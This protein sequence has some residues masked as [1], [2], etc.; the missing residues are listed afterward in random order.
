MYDIKPDLRFKACL[1]CDGSRVDPRGLST[2]AT[3]VKVISV[4][5]LDLI[6]DAHN[7]DVIVGDI[8]NAFI[9]AKTKEKIYTR[10]GKEF[11]DRAHCIVLIKRAL[12]GLTIGAA[13]FRTLLAVFLRTPDFK[14]TR[15][16][17]DVWIPLR[18]KKYGYAYICT[19]VDDF[20]IIARNPSF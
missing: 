17:R 15:F 2:R 11:R 14:P 6:A 4:C 3:V 7:L 18:D 16:D 9:Q 19:H 10:C 20:K 12:Y 5:L 13:C 8:G 1:V